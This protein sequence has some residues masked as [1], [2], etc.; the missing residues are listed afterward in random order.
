MKS[1]KYGANSD[2]KKGKTE[3]KKTTEKIKIR[4]KSSCPKIC[5]SF[6]FGTRLKS[7]G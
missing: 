4:Y 2:D 1:M 5:R 7:S 6:R 3:L